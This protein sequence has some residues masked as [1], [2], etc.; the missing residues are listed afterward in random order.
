MLLKSF[1]AYITLNKQAIKHTNIVLVQYITE[2]GTSYGATAT[3]EKG[4]LQWPGAFWLQIVSD[5][6]CLHEAGDTNGL[7]SSPFV[8]CISS[9]SSEPTH[10]F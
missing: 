3:K 9:A 10:I 4:H 2:F 1:Y 5:L 7:L 6:E 8:V